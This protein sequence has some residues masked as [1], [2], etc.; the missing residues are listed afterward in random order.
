MQKK[1]FSH[2]EAHIVA[3]WVIIIFSVLQY[4]ESKNF[5]L[6]SLLCIVIHMGPHLPPQE[7]VCIF[8]KKVKRHDFFHRHNV[9]MPKRFKTNEYL[10]SKFF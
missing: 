6:C 10:K 9:D 5:V 2:D 1:Q 3:G 8:V 7:Q 4:R